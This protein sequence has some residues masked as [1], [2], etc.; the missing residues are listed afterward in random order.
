MGR[1]SG[2]VPSYPPPVPPPGLP[3]PQACRDGGT[4]RRRADVSRRRASVFS[5]V[6]RGARRPGAPPL[7]VAPSISADA[8]SGGYRENSQNLSGFPRHR[9]LPPIPV[10]TPGSQLRWCSPSVFPRSDGHR[11][12]PHWQRPRHAPALGTNARCVRLPATV[13][14]G[15]VTDRCESASGVRIP[16]H[17]GLCLYEAKATS[18]TCTYCG[19]RL[20]SVLERTRGICASCYVLS[21]SG[22]KERASGPPQTGRNPPL[23]AGEPSS[24][25]S[26]ATG[27]APPDER[28]SPS[29]LDRGRESSDR[30]I[31]QAAGLSR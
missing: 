4:S 10:A 15:A 22:E 3:V 17:S 29:D 21:R 1:P 9:Q 5:K 12:H 19:G 13:Y 23:P 6:T 30:T 2:P 7:H 18:M 16:V 24:A 27:S 8:E 25:E 28:P 11:Q 14:R 26:A 20:T 31:S